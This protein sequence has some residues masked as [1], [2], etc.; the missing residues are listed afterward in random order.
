LVT[1]NVVSVAFLALLLLGI[2]SSHAS[3]TKYVF[4]HY[5]TP[6]FYSAN[7]LNQTSAANR[8]NWTPQIQDE[9]S[10]AMEAGLDGF[11]YNA[12]F[13]G[14]EA[15]ILGWA[16]VAD[17]IGATN[18]KAFISFDMSGDSGG[19]PAIPASAII[20]SMKAI[21][22]NPHTFRYN[23]LP[24]LST[25][26][27]DD[28]GN[29]WW[30]NNV[31]TPLANAG[32]PVTFVPYFDRADQNHTQPTVANWQS[33][34]NNFPSVNGLFNFNIPGAP[35]FYPTDP[36]IGHNWS[37]ALLGEEALAAALHN[38][39]KIFVAPFSPSWWS[40]CHSAR[41]YIETQGGLGMDNWWNSII[42]IQ[43]PEIVEIVT[44][45]DW[46]EAFISPSTYAPLPTEAAGIETEQHIGYY[47]L[48]KYYI[49]WY[50]NGVKPTIVKDGIFYFHRIQPMGA[51]I[52]GN[53]SACTMPP[54]STDQLWG[55]PQ[56]DI[57]VTTALTAPAT[58]TVISGGT[59]QS[60][61]VA[62]G[63]STTEVPFQPGAQTLQLW[64][65]GV[66]LTEASSHS[67]I[68]SPTTSN[69]NVYSGYSISNGTS[70]ATWAPSN[71]FLTGYRADWFR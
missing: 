58:L 19:N 36:N 33:V 28:L 13:T 18:F 43:N 53:S 62:G 70:S 50:R 11:V 37:S 46:S 16:S 6:M 15:A 52:T 56:D 49:Q 66:K 23:G 31:L 35:P 44:W 51:A 2:S 9:I 71:K 54:P 34:I 30:Q 27:G 29:S 59:S 25:Y 1:K 48:L 21:Y 55:L 45:N 10:A 22:N 8:A 60:F 17:A 3:A 61:N 26:G 42:N 4:A 67:I 57:Y 12:Y 39:G 64:R 47:E 20:A 68:A 14:S 69:Y 38:F 5:G 24:V 32:Y 65:D 40:V 63:L 41:Q 7:D